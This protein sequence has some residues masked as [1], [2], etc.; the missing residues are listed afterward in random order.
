MTKS[1]KHADA[2]YLELMISLIISLALG[3]A[4]ITG[5]KGI[6]RG[7]EGSNLTHQLRNELTT[8]VVNAPFQRG[9]DKV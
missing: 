6:M 3:L 4:L 2:G 1:K 7:T 8:Q 5:S 9:Y